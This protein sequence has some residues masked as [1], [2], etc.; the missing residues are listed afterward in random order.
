MEDNP[1]DEGLFLRSLRKCGVKNEV[2]VARTG[3]EALDYLFGSGF[4]AGRDLTI[5]P[6]VII[7]DLKIPRLDG[8]EVLYRLRRDERTSLLPV[9]VFTSSNEPHDKLNAYSLGANSYLFKPVD[10]AQFS[11]VVRQIATYWLV[12]NQTLQGKAAPP[13]TPKENGPPGITLVG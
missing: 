7:L 3:P 2:V 6:E 12:M 11:E 13:W 10:F 5:M 8:L 4:H 9:V 1:G